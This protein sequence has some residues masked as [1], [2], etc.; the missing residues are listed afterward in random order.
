[1]LT[2]NGGN[3]M[4]P[5]WVLFF[6]DLNCPL[7]EVQNSILRKSAVLILGLPVLL[8]MPLIG[9]VE[10]F[11]EAVQWIIECWRGKR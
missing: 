2:T 4:E 1:M 10:A 11:W 6:E 8:I 7:D 3:E 5:K 9:A